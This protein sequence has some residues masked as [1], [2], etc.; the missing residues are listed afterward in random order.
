MEEL[1]DARGGLGGHACCPDDEKTLVKKEDLVY[2]K[3]EAS[4]R[5]GGEV[6]DAL[7][8]QTLEI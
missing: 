7:G 6:L 1:D 3:L 2:G 8:T 4:A 5:L